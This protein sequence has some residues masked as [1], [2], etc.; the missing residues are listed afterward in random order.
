LH[1]VSLNTD[2]VFAHSAD[3]E[4]GARLGG[5]YWRGDLQSDFGLDFAGVLAKFRLS[6]GT[7]GPRFALGAALG[8]AF[9]TPGAVA[10]EGGGFLGFD[11]GDVVDLDGQIDVSLYLPEEQD[12]FLGG[13]V[14]LGPLWQP[15]DLL[16]VAFDVS[17]ELSQWPESTD[18]LTWSVEAALRVGFQL[19]GHELALSGRRHLIGARLD[20]ETAAVLTWRFVWVTEE[21]LLR[22]DNDGGPSPEP[23]EGDVPLEGI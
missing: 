22:L 18:L 19:G 10:L 5:S 2:F 16:N 4:L 20:E 13:G 7:S 23:E 15:V 1:R 9:R 11:L 6:D 8:R 14:R 12:A 21:G 17:G 3:V